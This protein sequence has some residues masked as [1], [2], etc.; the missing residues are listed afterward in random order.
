MIDSDSI[1]QDSICK[2]LRDWLECML[3]AADP[4]V[5]RT[6]ERTGRMMQGVEAALVCPLLPPLL[7]HC[8]VRALAGECSVSAL[9][10]PGFP[11]T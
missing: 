4:F 10:L 8:V 11:P 7:P 5:H 3:G 6:W 2:D 1:C 9:R